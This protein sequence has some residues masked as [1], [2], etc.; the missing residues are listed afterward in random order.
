VQGVINSES[1]DGDCDEVMRVDK[2]N[3]EE[4]FVL[5]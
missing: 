5:Y 1:E 3:Q 4:N 2:L